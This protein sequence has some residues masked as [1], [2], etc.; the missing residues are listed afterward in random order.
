[1]QAKEQPEGLT[2]DS[3]ADLAG[4]ATKNLDMVSTR[5]VGQRVM[6]WYKGPG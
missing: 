3:V 1:M 6:K 5:S 4:A 2:D